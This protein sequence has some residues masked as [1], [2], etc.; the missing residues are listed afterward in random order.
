MAKSKPH[1][2]PTDGRVG[3]AESLSGGAQALLKSSGE[4]M[5]VMGLDASLVLLL[6]CNRDLK[7]MVKLDRKGSRTSKVL[8]SLQDDAVPTEMPPTLASI[9]QHTVHNTMSHT[10]SDKMSNMK[11]TN[12]TDRQRDLQNKNR[13]LIIMNLGALLTRI[14]S[15][16]QHSPW[17][18]G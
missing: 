14:G 16:E 2:Y 13:S 7:R 9:L 10:R 1:S 17:A 6:Q 11:R 15:R 18:R 12:V 8:H 3:R 4:I 5:T